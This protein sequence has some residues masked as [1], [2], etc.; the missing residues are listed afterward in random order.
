M[1][2]EIH[3]ALAP[4]KIS[5]AQHGTSGNSSDRLREIVAKTNTTKANVATALQMI[6]WGLEVND[7]GNAQLDKDGNFI[8]VENEGVTEAMWQEMLAYANENGLKGGNF[9]KLNR[10]FESKLLSQPRDIRDR[11]AKRVENFIY[12]MLTDVLNSGDTAPLAIEAICENGTHDP[13]PKASRIEDPAQWTPEKIT[14]RAA[15][16]ESDKGP[17]GDF[18]D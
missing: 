6:S 7:Y 16:I 12:N 1:T 5:G 14:E 10:P 3:N 9:K 13:G 17:E 11:M 2:A 8:K 4:Y 18:D 15:T